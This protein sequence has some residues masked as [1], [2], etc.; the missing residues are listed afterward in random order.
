MAIAQ[1]QAE[2][3]VDP[4]ALCFGEPEDPEGVGEGAVTGSRW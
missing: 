4:H 3:R 2:H 1:H